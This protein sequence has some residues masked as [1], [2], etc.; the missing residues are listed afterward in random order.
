MTGWRPAFILS[1]DCGSLRVLS[2]ESIA[3][4]VGDPTLLLAFS[5]ALW[6]SIPGGGPK[7]R[8]ISSL[9]L[10]GSTSLQSFCGSNLAECF[11]HPTP[12][13]DFGSLQH[14]AGLEGLHVWQASNSAFVPPS[15]FGY[16]LDV[17]LPS[18][19]GEPC[20]M[21]TALVGFASSKHR[22]PVKSHC[23]SAAVHPHA[24][25]PTSDTPARGG[26]RRRRP[27]LLGFDPLRLPWLLAVLSHASEPR[28]SHE[29]RPS[30]VVPHADLGPPSG[31]LLSCA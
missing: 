21:L 9:T 8:S 7:H 29:V 19:P 15:G 20:F 4:L 3:V 1:W 6:F 23:V 5:S 16:P 2:P 26:I 12:L 28:S 27:R 11:Q 14:I 13:L 31:A 24:V 25:S 22:P 18:G 17:L 10:T 30:R